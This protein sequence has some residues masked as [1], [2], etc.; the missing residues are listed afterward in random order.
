M[1]IS[2]LYYPQAA[3]R[4]GDY[5]FNSGIQVEI[6]SARDS[7]FDWSKIHFTQQYREKLSI[8]RGV[9]ASIE[10]GYNNIYDETFTGYVAQPYSSGANADEIV[11]KDEMLLLEDITV[12]NTFLETTPQEI[13]TYILSQAGITKMSLSAQVYPARKRV[14]IYGVSGIKAI[15]AVNAAW[16]IR[17][18]FFFSGGVFYWGMTP[19]QEKVYAFQYGVNILALSRAGGEWELE[20]V[21]APFVRHSHKIEVTHPKVAGTFEVTKVVFLTNDA[22][23]I[24]TYIYF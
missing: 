24:R 3:A 6:H 12:S 4:A 16:G 7:Y 14:P 23:F 5:F 11:L 9:P 22:G 19:T 15:E 1:E 18:R 2:E 8:A 10:L 20:T 13:I 17:Q 21:S